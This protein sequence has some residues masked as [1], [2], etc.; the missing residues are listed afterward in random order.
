MK[1]PEGFF[2]SKFYYIILSLYLIFAPY[3]RL[4]GFEYHDSQRIW[5]LF[6]ISLLSLGFLYQWY[7]K[8]PK[9][10]KLLLNLSAD[11][12][13]FYLLVGISVLG[14]ISVFLSEYIEYALLEYSFTF[15]L[16]LLVIVLSPISQKGLFNFGRFI[17]ITAIIYA[18][19]YVIIFIGNYITSFLDPMVVLWPN[20]ITY[21]ITIGETTLTGKDIL[22]F[23]NKRFFNHTQT[24]TFPI[25]LSAI[26]FFKKRFRGQFR[27]EVI[28][29]YVLTS[30]WWLLV[31]AS[32]GRGTL[33]AV[34]ASSILVL[35]I[36]KEE[37]A[38][39]VKTCF[40]TLAAGLGGY[41]FFYIYLPV[42]REAPLLRFTDNN[43]FDLW[44]NGL[45]IW[46]ENPFF[47][48]GPMHYAVLEGLP[49][50]A[51]PHNF[52]IQFLSEWGIFSFI[53]LAGIIFLFARSIFRLNKSPK[54]NHSRSIVAIGMY[55][56]MGAALIHSLV[57]GI[58]HTPMS[59]MW[60]VVILGWLLAWNYK[61]ESRLFNKYI[62]S[63][64][65]IVLIV[66]ILVLTVPIIDDLSATYIDYLQKYPDSKLWPRFWGQGLIPW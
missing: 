4:P 58:M 15:L 54:L 46:T 6:I 59:Q 35:M 21:S 48:V 55:V 64:L 28:L 61:K 20:K 22:Y 52:F 56:S 36:F 43:R 40:S 33:I 38:E 3:L 29:L 50:E 19:I 66:T 23:S 47:G 45:E 7:L 42:K 32:G 8:K 25:L 60:F 13:G 10:E 14:L 34:I 18:S 31:F 24:W 27:T 63:T 57:S 44:L 41:L 39:F 11:S 49:E 62:L 1:H 65:L 30:I 37:A 51:H 9:T 26:V 53:F 2:M 16:V 17:Y 12:T 5:Q